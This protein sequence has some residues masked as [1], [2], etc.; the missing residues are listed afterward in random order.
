MPSNHFLDD[1]SD[2]YIIQSRLVISVIS[3]LFSCKK[4]SSRVMLNR[5]D[6]EH[7]SGESIQENECGYA[8]F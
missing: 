2:V 3:A 8:Y 1:G 4:Q 6:I 5:R 7:A